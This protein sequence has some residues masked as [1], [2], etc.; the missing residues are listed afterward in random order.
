MKINEVFEGGMGEVG[1]GKGER[2][3]LGLVFEIKNFL[4]KKVSKNDF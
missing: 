3:E 1:V 2:G 4:S